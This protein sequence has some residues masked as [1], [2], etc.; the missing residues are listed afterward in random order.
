MSAACLNCEGALALRGT[1]VVTYDF[2]TQS[3]VVLPGPRFDPGEGVFFT[4]DPNWL[5]VLAGVEPS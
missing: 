3:F 4:L 5:F 2:F 1:A